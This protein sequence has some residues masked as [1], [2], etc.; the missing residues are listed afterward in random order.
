VVREV[1]ESARAMA[2]MALQKVG[3]SGSAVEQAEEVYRATDKERLS[4]Q[5][6]AGDIRAAREIILT[7]ARRTD[8]AGES[9]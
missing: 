1:L 7:Q 2:R 8:P 6:A 5:I 4:K 3:L 9:G